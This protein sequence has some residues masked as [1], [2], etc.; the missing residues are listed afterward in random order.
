MKVTTRI[1]K[2]V[3]EERGKRQRRACNDGEMSVEWTETPEKGLGLSWWFWPNFVTELQP[4][5]SVRNIKEERSQEEG[6]AGEKKKSLRGKN[7]IRRELTHLAGSGT[8]CVIWQSHLYSR[9]LLTSVKAE[10]ILCSLKW[11]SDN[12]N[13]VDPGWAG[14]GLATGRGG[15][16]SL[17]ASIFLLQPASTTTLVG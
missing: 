2:R 15:W 3:V 13:S 9:N 11:R 16:P 6:R 12:K 7:D 8:C 5:P 17:A 14:F 10:L 1:N 4:H